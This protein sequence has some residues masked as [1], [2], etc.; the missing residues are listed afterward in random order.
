MKPDVIAALGPDDLAKIET[1]LQT[2]V[3]EAGARCAF[4]RR[5]P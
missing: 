1:L 2:F 4:R 3:V 5:I